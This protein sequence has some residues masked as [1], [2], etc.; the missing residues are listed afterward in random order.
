MNL[1]SQAQKKHEPPEVR[2][3][4]CF[5]YYLTLVGIFQPL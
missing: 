2:D 1:Q 3:D 5:V 4:S